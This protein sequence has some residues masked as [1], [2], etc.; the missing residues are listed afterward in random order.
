MDQRV[1]VVG[2]AFSLVGLSALGEA[3]KSAT[4]STPLPEATKKQIYWEGFAWEHKAYREANAR[5]PIDRPGLDAKTAK[6]NGEYG[7]QL[8]AKYDAQLRKKYGISDAQYMRIIEE[9]MAK[10]WPKPSSDVSRN[11]VS[12]GADCPRAAQ[13]ETGNI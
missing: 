1:I 4:A 5:Y 11:Q 10:K 8:I 3:P 7:D 9:G 12:E 6:A 13:R 2:I